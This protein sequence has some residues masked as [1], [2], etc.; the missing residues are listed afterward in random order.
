MLGSE[1]ATLIPEETQL[2][3]RSTPKRATAAASERTVVTSKAG[4]QGWASEACHELVTLR[5]LLALPAKQSEDDWLDPQRFPSFAKPF[6]KRRGT[7]IGSYPEVALV[8]CPNCGTKNDDTATPC[9]KC[10]F[11]LSGASAPKF[12]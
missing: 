7:G 2:Q 9:K 4:C 6:G 1:P 8:F 12:R 5:R 11:K 10:G 3:A